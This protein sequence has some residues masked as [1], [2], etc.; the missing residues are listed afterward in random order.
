MWLPIFKSGTHKDSKGREKTWTESD[1]DKIVTT[2]NSQKDHEA[3][4]VIGHPTTDA[5]AWGWVESLKRQG[6]ILVAKLKDLAP[7]LV[8]WVKQGRYKKVSAS[9][10]PNL[11]L[12][13]A[14]FLGAAPPAVK[15]LPAAQFTASDDD[16]TYEFSDLD[17]EKLTWIARIFRRFKQFLIEKYDM[18]TA[19]RILSDWEIE[20]L[21]RDEQNF[22]EQTPDEKREAQKARAKKYGI[23]PKE[24]GNLTKPSEYDALD[25]DEFADPVNYRYPI[26]SEHIQAALS[27]WGMAKNREQY[28]ADEVEKITKRILAAAKKFEI[29]VDEKKWEFVE[30]ED[31]EKVKELEEQLRAKENE[32][33]QARAALAKE[34]AAKRQSDHLSFCEGLASGGKLTPAQKPAVLD[35]MEILFNA[36]EFEFSEGEG[37]DGKLKRA[38]KSALDVFKEFLNALPKQVDY[39]EHAT[40]GKAPGA[41]NSGEALEFSG[42]ID[43]ERLELHKKAMMLVES[44]KLSYKDAV[45]KVL[46][47]EGG[48]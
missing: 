20:Q 3:P 25:D 8:D 27:Y 29:E 31:M 14:G 10:Y 33:K 9:F 24:G 30:G 42:S 40:K 38:K 48:K 16:M 6:K 19:D 28:T 17:S 37:D 5:P 46:Q 12:K 2:Y 47:K 21:E 13:H 26:D 34:Q 15:G 35:F 22:A 23:E 1:L 18:E 36:G 4:V 7:E 11:L 43:E 39:N 32:L 41:P 44:E 45:K